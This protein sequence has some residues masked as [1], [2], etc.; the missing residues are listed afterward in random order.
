LSLPDLLARTPNRVGML[1]AP[2]FLFTIL[3]DALAIR[4]RGG[5]YPWGNTG[6]SVM[7]AAGH[8]I[9]QAAVHG[10]TLLGSDA[11][12]FSLTYNTDNAS[13]ASLGNPTFGLVTRDFT[14]F[15]EAGTESGMSR[16]WGG[17]HYN[18]DVADG[19]TLGQEV[20]LNALDQFAPEAVPEPA[21]AALL[22]A[23]VCGLGAV[24]RRSRRPG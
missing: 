22:I 6:V 4:A 19:F 2:L 7:L 8:V 3:A 16:I 23:A 9:S 13:A 17:I 12:D 11:A 15:S 18:F 10:P 24:R 21:S 20:A 1:F 5:R 14:S